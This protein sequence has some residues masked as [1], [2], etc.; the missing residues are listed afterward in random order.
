MVTPSKAATGP[1]A[2]KWRLGGGEGWNNVSDKAVIKHHCKLHPCLPCVHLM[3]DHSHKQ[4]SRYA[5]SVLGGKL[6][7]TVSGIVRHVQ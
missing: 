3:A 1:M 6:S 5:F 4:R 7:G 2:W